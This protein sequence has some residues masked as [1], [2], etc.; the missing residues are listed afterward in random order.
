MF[1]CSLYFCIL[2]YSF[3]VLFMEN[4]LACPSLIF[5]YTLSLFLSSS[6][7]DTT[8]AGVLPYWSNKAFSLSLSFGRYKCFF[9]LGNVVLFVLVVFLLICV[10]SFQ[11]LYNEIRGVIKRKFTVFHVIKFSVAHCVRIWFIELKMYLE[12]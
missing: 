9:Y 11:F 3:L 8:K 2:R 6:F 10:M 7:H 1:W 5:S 4:H 12:Y